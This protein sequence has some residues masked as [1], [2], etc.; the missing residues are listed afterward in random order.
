MKNLEMAR[1]IHERKQLD[2]LKMKEPS[3][4]MESKAPEKGS[5]EG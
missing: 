2:A 5:K 4:K 3:T 1:E